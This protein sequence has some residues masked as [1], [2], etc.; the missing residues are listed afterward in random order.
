MTD[1]PHP[2]TWEAECAA[3]R[4]ENERLWAVLDKQGRVRLI[5]SATFPAPPEPKDPLAPKS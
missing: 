4:A 5:N 1:T 3:L 2:S